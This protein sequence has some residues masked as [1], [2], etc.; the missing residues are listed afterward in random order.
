MLAK[1]NGR[2][3]ICAAN[4][5]RMMR[6][7]VPYE[8]MKGIPA[9]IIDMPLPKA[10]L[11]FTEAATRTLEIYEPRLPANMVVQMAEFYGSEAKIIIETKCRNGNV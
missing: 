3:E 10:S 9:D 4:L 8:R 5:L 2:P 1:G 6:Y 11:Y 7:E